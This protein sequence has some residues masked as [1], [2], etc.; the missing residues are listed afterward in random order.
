M[1]RDEYMEIVRRIRAANV[2]VSLS[3]LKQKIMEEIKRRNA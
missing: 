1:S 3:L 2:M